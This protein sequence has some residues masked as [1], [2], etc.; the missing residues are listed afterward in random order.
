MHARGNPTYAYEYQLFRR[1]IQIGADGSI[2]TDRAPAY[3]LLGPLEERMNEIDYF[4]GFSW[5][6]PCAQMDDDSEIHAI[7][8][9]STS[10]S[11]FTVRRIISLQ[12]RWRETWKRRHHEDMVR[13]ARE[14]IAL[15]AEARRRGVILPSLDYERKVA[16]RKY[17]RW[18]KQ[19]RARERFALRCPMSNWIRFN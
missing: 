8:M 3:V 17:D 13:L 16:A 7:S 15:Y 11:G 4:H 10:H 5:S 12:R 18:T 2:L 14:F 19:Q 9:I 6:C 1:G